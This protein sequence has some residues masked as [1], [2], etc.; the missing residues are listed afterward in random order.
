MHTLVGPLPRHLYCFAE[1][2]FFRKGGDGFEP[3]VWFGLVSHKA[4]TWGCTVLTEEG[5]VY[6]NL[7]PH[8]IAFKRDAGPWSAH[9]AQ[10]WNVYGPGFA[11]VEYP[12]LY[13]LSCRAMVKGLEREQEYDGHYLFTAAPVGDAYS[14][15]PEQAKEFVFVAL[16]NGR[17][18]IQPTNAVLFEDMSFV[19]PGAAWP[20]DLKRQTEVYWC[21]ETPARRG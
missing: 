15:Y 8:A 1:R 4:R 14:E 16:G 17:L 10:R 18:T 19:K 9:H 11:V 6:R 2:S 20:T 3:V 21:D 5:A 7:P 12:Y 13:G